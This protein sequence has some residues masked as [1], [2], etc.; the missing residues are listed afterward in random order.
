MREDLHPAVD[1]VS[2]G[3]APHPEPKLVFDVYYQGP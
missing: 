3:Q 2:G 1:E